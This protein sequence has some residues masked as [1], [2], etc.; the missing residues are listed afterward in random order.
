M[1]ILVYG[2][3]YSVRAQLR[4]ARGPARDCP[5]PSPVLCRIAELRVEVVFLSLM[6]NRLLSVVARFR[7]LSPSM[8]RC[9]PG[10]F[11]ACSG[12]ASTILPKATP[13]NYSR[14]KEWRQRLRR[15]RRAIP[16][17]TTPPRNSLPTSPYRILVV[18]DFEPWRMK[19][20]AMLQ[21]HPDLKVIGEAED[22]LEAVRKAEELKPD[23]ILLDI[24][25]PA[26]SGIEA[27]ERI[28]KIVPAAKI[29]FVTQENDPDVAATALSNGAKG[30]VL[31]VNAH[32]ELL[33]AVEAILDGRRFL[34]SG[35]S[36]H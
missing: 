30:L 4:L 13:Y 11:W 34:G 7:Q 32:R 21:S 27:A 33:P 28:S 22:G 25:M 8:K 31:K 26:L 10:A 20:C 1:S 5:P 18:D 16:V 29:L 35:V 15:Q 24:G 36:V 19:V 6:C 17:S 12:P 9:P 23:L 2:R 3:C 14:H